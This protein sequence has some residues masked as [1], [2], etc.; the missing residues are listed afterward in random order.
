[1]DLYRFDQIA[2]L[3]TSRVSPG[4]TLLD[5]YVVL[6]HLDPESR[7]LCAEAGVAVNYPSC[8]LA[9]PRVG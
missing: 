7:R 6:E 5:R 4:D 3:I 1:M 2:E 8:V 9:A